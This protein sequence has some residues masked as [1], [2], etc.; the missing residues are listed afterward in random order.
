MYD[1]QGKYDPGSRHG[2]SAIVVT[3][4]SGPALKECLYALNANAEVDEI[5][6]VN[7]G[8]DEPT[9]EWLDAYR[10]TNN[11]C[12]FQLITG[13][14]NIGMGPGVNL[15]ARHATAGRFLIINPD[16]VLRVGS[17]P[18]LESARTLGRSPCLVGGKIFYPSGREQRGGRRELLTL[19]RAIVSFTGLSKLEKLV[20]AFRN[21]HREKDPE[22][23]GPVDMPVISGAFC[24]ISR[25]D[26]ETV[27]GFDERYFLHVEDIDLCRTIAEMG[28]QVIYTPKAG[29]LHYGSTSKV[30]R[31]FVEWHKAKGLSK[32]FK[33]YSKT[34]LERVVAGASLYA[35]AA[36]LMGRSSAIR[37][38]HRIRSLFR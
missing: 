13:H 20:P 34:P 17:I 30:S 33:K 22:P 7:N 24:Y 38:F 28:G 2:V 25:D 3:F 8:N 29:A 1:M 31:N 21:V 19:P 36:L 32:Y 6:V 37:T 12:A 5:V 26:F 23:E 4:H 35:F 15:G 14:G 18:E 11:R 27:G 10:Q 9:M 16:A